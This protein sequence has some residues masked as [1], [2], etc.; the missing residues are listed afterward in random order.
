M[1][2]RNPQQNP[3]EE[4][5]V[6]ATWLSEP[7]AAA[8][9]FER[10][11]STPVEPT[12]EKF[13]QR[14]RQAA[15]KAAAARDIAKLKGE[16]AQLSFVPMSLAEML[17]GLARLAGVQLAPLIKG[18]RTEELTKTNVETIV[19]LARLARQI[20]FSLREALAHVR[21]GFAIAQGSAPPTLLLARQRA[22]HARQSQLEACESLLAQL[23]TRYD[24]QTLRQ[25]RHLED[26]VRAE[27]ADDDP[28]R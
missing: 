14:S 26:A 15:A 21:L 7:L 2:D 12:P 11:T 10:F 24:T 1:I 5:R 13:L 25:L 16:R 20:G 19:A 8:L 9:A 3:G 18:R 22:T 28:Q 17:D 6:P 23:E 27:F 4:E